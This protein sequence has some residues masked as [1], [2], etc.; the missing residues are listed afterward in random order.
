MV[1]SV[2]WPIKQLNGEGASITSI[3]LLIV[4]RTSPSLNV[5]STFK[6]PR[7]LVVDPSKP[8]SF[9]PLGGHKSFS[10]NLRVW[11]RLEEITLKEALPNSLSL[12]LA[13]KALIT[14]RR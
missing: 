14:N 10:E 13:M 12:W 8:E 9:P 3:L 11:K 1:V 2:V 6:V 5:M 7:V 4:R